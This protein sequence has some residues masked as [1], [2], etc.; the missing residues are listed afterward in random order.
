MKMRLIN[1]AS[2]DTAVMA[3]AVFKRIDILTI[4]CQLVKQRFM[5]VD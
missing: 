3:T 1:A 2:H 4:G 5:E